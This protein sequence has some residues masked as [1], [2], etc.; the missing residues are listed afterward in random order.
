[1][2]VADALLR[3]LV[4]G[5]DM[6]ISSNA[7]VLQPSEC[8]ST[9]LGRWVVPWARARSKRDLWVD[10]KPIFPKVAS[11]PPPSPSISG[12]RRLPGT[13][14][15]LLG[16]HL[17]AAAALAK[18]TCAVCAAAARADARAAVCPG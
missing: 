9:P 5:A 15:H 14:R 11:S 13:Q 17:Q 10:G 7:M 8:L 12:P 1:M 2:R 4:R 3:G 16:P 18:S 6:A